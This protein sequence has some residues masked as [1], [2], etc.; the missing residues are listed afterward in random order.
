MSRSARLDKFLRL[1]D[2]E[3]RLASPLERERRPDNVCLSHAF[4]LKQKSSCFLTKLAAAHGAVDV[5]SLSSKKCRAR[6]ARISKTG[7]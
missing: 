4:Q 6:F 7:S 5:L 3:R 1:D 2:P